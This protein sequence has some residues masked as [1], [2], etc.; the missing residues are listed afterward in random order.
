MYEYAAKKEVARYKAYCCDVLNRLKQKLEKEHIQA[1]V[2][3]VGSGAEDMVTRNGKGPFDL[4]YNLVLT[5]IP[6]KYEDF[7]G[8]LRNRVRE[9]M[10]GLVDGRFSHGKGSTSVLTYL[11]HPRDRSR[12]EFKFDVALV[13]G[14]DGKYKLVHDKGSNVFIWNQVPY[15]KKL[16]KKI[17]AVRRNGR[18]AD[19]EEA[20]LDLKNMYLGRGDKHHPSFIVLAEAVNQVYQSTGR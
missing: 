20:Y 14:R 12:V 1:Y 2:T 5:S 6:Q 4:D 3:L 15:S 7:P 19:V 18:W 8:M 10:D 16:D 17:A 13:W 9:I 11:A